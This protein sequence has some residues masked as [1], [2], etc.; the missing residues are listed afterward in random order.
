VSETKV[1]KTQSIVYFC[2]SGHLDQSFKT[3]HLMAVLG[4][5]NNM[6]ALSSKDLIIIH[7][8]FHAIYLAVVFGIVLIP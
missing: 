1:E 7:E 3:W 2:D 4:R 5:S 8:S 6:C